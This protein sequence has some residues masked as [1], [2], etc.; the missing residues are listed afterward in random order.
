MLL[1]SHSYSEKSNWVE[2]VVGIGVGIF[3]V[4]NVQNLPGSLETHPY[5]IAWLVGKVIVISIVLAIILGILFGL[6]GVKGKTQEDE[7][8]VSIRRKSTVWAYWS[9]HIGIVILLVQAFL[10]VVLRLETN[11]DQDGFFADLPLVDFLFHGLMILTMLTQIMQ[12]S[13]EIFFQRRGY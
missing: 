9:L 4:T 6:A 7:R 1:K 8:D 12:N 2:L 5:A 11:V 13:L 10:N 3:Y